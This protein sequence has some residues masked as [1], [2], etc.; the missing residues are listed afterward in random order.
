MTQNFI[1]P[2]TC[3][4]IGIGVFENGELGYFDLN[5]I[6]NCHYWGFTLLDENDGF[7][8]VVPQDEECF[9][10]MY[11][12]NCRIYH[13]NISKEDECYRIALEYDD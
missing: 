11:V 6:N 8:K 10:Y 1:V 12:N 7:T 2:L 9:D 5:L 13:I 3:N 4:F